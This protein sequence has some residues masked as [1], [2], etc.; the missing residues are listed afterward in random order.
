[1]W[2]CPI[3]YISFYLL[4]ENPTA[5][6]WGRH[7]LRMRLF[8]IACQHLSGFATRMRGKSFFSAPTTTMWFVGKRIIWKFGNILTTIRPDG[9]KIAFTRGNDYEMSVLWQ[10]DERRLFSIRGTTHPMDSKRQQTVYME[11]GRCEGCCCDGRRFSHEILS[12]RGILLL[13]LQNRNCTR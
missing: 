8:P 6:R 9:K 12:S 13:Q 1:M 5:G 4:T 3:M 11:N 7:P 2:L 10:G